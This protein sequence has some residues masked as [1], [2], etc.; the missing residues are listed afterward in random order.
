MRRTLRICLLEQ[1]YRL[2]GFVGNP[3]RRRISAA[4]I[5]PSFS[6]RARDRAMMSI[7]HGFVLKLRDS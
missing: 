3:N 4:E 2:R 6:R 7:N 1:I 5:P